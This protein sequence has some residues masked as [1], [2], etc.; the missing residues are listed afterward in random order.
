MKIVLLRFRV[1]RQKDHL[2]GCPA[3]GLLGYGACR[4]CLGAQ[5]LA[6]KSVFSWFSSQPWNST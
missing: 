3:A 6:G 2:S 4:L 1:F 5:S